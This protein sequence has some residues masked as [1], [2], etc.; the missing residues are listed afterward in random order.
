MTHNFHTETP[1]ENQVI[2]AKTKDVK[3]DQVE[4]RDGIAYLWRYKS[5]GEVFCQ[6]ADISSWRGCDPFDY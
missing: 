6:S 4:I 5:T 3:I 1:P 2:I